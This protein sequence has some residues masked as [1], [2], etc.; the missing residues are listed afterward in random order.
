MKTNFLIIL[1]FLYGTA[2]AAVSP[3]EAARLGG[4]ELTPIGAER[5]GNADGTIPAWTGGITE[6]PEGYSPGQR[7]RDPFPEDE[8]LFTITAA[9]NVRQRRSSIR[10]ALISLS[11]TFP[12]EN[13]LTRFSWR[14]G[15]ELVP[16]W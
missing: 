14:Q 15:L 13:G 5:P 9:N 12:Q 16:T 6:I 1:I 10:I 11:P 7:H 4:P 8:V 2:I 3:E